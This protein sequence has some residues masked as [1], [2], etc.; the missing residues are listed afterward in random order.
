[1]IGRLK[2]LSPR[3]K[4][5]DV[6]LNTNI[7]KIL[8]I[9]PPKKMFMLVWRAILARFFTFIKSLSLLCS[10]LS[11]PPKY[12]RATYAIELIDNMIELN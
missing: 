11:F 6:C 1:M 3:E 2:S 7:N 8:T 10:A 4:S 12:N 9:K 5:D